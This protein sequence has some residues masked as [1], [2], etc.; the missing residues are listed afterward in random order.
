MYNDSVYV[1]VYNNYINV[2]MLIL[3]G[4]YLLIGGQVSIDWRAG[5]YCL[6]EVST[7]IRP[8]HLTNQITEFLDAIL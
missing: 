4:R 7:R 2:S 5:I 8:L 3:A 1:N 6:A